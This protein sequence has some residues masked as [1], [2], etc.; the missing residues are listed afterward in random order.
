MKQETILVQ[1]I[2][3]IGEAKYLLFELIHDEIFN[4]LSKHNPYFHDS[5]KLNDIRCK[6]SMIEEKISEA[7]E[8]LNRD[9]SNGIY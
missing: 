9:Y 6:L 2:Q 1:K 8:V 7:I 5:E 4:C 3:D